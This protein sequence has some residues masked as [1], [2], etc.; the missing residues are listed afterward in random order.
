[1]RLAKETMSFIEQNR[2]KPFFAYL[3]FYSVHTPLM[4]PKELVAKYKEKYQVQ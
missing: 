2:E 1:M 4:G 3:S